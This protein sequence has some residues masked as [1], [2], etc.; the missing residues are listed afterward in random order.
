MVPQLTMYGRGEFF[1]LID[2]TSKIQPSPQR[3]TRRA[4]FLPV[5]E[6]LSLAA[7]VAATGFSSGA[8]AHS[9]I[10]TQNLSQQI[11]AGF[12]DS[13]ASLASL[14]RQITS[15]AQVAVQN[16]RTLDLLTADKGGTCLFLREE[17]CCCINESGLEE[18]R[19]QSLHKL[20]DEMRCYNA[21]WTDTPGYW[22]SPLFDILTPLMGP[23]VIICLFLLLAPF[24]FRFFQDRLRKLTWVTFNQMLLHV[25]GY[26]PLPTGSAYTGQAAQD[27]PSP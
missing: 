20:S 12:E 18:T 15:P 5:L 24:L 13:A 9:V 4:V 6:G 27:I 2:L 19:V 26:Q 14:Q 11:L 16:H 3:R 8:L 10:L 23:L 7:S 17:C 21:A 25:Q 22:N 1:Q